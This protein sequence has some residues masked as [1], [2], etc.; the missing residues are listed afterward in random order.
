M[1]SWSTIVE[2]EFFHLMKHPDDQQRL[3]P[4][5]D[6]ALHPD[7]N[8]NV[9]QL[10]SNGLLLWLWD[11]A[12]VHGSWDTTRKAFTRRDNAGDIPHTDIRAWAALDHPVAAS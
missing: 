10:T 4:T 6:D 1:M 3:W 11:G 7:A 9:K 2:I 8:T 5:P 12:L